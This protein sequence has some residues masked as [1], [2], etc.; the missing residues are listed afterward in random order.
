MTGMLVD[1]T[2]IEDPPLTSPLLS[3]VEIVGLVLAAS[4]QTAN[5]RSP[6][7]ASQ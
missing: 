7:V 3:R 6:F 2:A 4:L 5:F 1:P